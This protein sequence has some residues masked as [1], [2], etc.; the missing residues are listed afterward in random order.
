MTCKDIMNIKELYELKFYGG[1]KGLSRMVRW[2]YFVDSSTSIRNVKTLGQWVSGGELFVCAND[3]VLEDKE[4]IIETIKSANFYNA[5]GIILNVGG[6]EPEYVELADQLNIPLFEIPW[7]IRLVDLSQIICTQLI[8]EQTE[9]AS[10]ELL[11]NNLIFTDLTHDDDFMTSNRYYDFDLTKKNRIAIF[12]LCKDNV[13]RKSDLKEQW[14]SQF[15]I[16]IQNSFTSFG[17]NRIT[18]M[19]LKDDIIVI[20]SDDVITKNDFKELV[21]NVG[22][23]W[24]FSYLNSTFEVSVGN[25]YSGSMNVKK[26]YSEAKKTLK[27]MKIVSDK[28]CVFFEDLGIYSLLFNSEDRNAFERFYKNQLGRLIEYDEI[29][30]AQLCQTLEAYFNNDK[31]AGATADS[32]FI[33]RNTLRYRFDKIHNLLGKDFENMNNAVNYIIAFKTKKYLEATLERV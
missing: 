11:L 29:N 24:S 22:K 2:L 7:S 14:H 27:L 21:E 31:N 32:L 20:Y 18:S 28:S 25:A 26:S 33:H 4:L 10:H 17:V 5:S 15:Y 16:C 23:E 3:K 19:S 6:I 12:H 1:A 9:A 13:Q 30:N 8:K